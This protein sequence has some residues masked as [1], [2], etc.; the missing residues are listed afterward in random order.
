MDQTKTMPRDYYEILGIQKDTNKKDIKSA[1]LKLAK[2]FHPDVNDAPDAEA[3]FKEIN[4]AYEILYDEDKRA[5]YDRFGH[6]GVSGQ[7]GFS[8]SSGFPGFEEIFEE[9]FSS[10]GGRGGGSRGRRRGPQPGADRRVNITIDF[11]E[12]VF[13]TEREISFDRLTVCE[14]CDGDGAKPGT[15][16]S[17]CQQ[18]N[19][20]GEVRQVQQTFLGSMVRVTPC[21]N[22]G[23]KGTV[24]K[25]RCGTCDGSGRHRK[26]V[27]LNVDI[28]AG[29]RE[30]LQIQVR[31]E[32]DAGEKGAPSG[33][34][35]VVVDVKEHEFFIRRDN[36]ILLEIPINVVQATLGDKIIIPTV[37]GDVE[38]TI[39]AGTQN[40][41][42]FRLRG[43]GFPRLRSD[44]SNSGRSDQLVHVR[45]EIP[46]KLDEEQRAAFE[47]LSE[48]LGSEVQPQ[49]NGKGFLGRVM[50]M[51]AGE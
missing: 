49:P 46:T 3:K 17:P 32:G 15:E 14:T 31:G 42:I 5:R 28:P 20:S 41:K 1:F 27:T 30:G 38:L 45:V 36:D 24:I 25:S 50:N 8:G 47:Q 6:E 44:G 2:Q 43:R 40:G 48:V 7:G 11:D 22:C 35:Y 12:A 23:G 19:G 21:P 16:S 4:E 33:N 13:G 18:C 51:F 26:S 37:D 9:F 34:L 29:V 39:P 10:F